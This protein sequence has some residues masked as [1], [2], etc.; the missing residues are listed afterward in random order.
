MN[1]IYNTAKRD[2]LNG[3]HDWDSG[4]QV[5]KVMLL[6]PGYTPDPD[7]EFVSSLAAYEIAGT[8][9]TGGFGGSG[10]KALVNRQVVADQANNRAEADADDVSWANATLVSV[11]AA[12]VYREGTSDAD[13]KLIA[14]F[15]SGFPVSPTAVDLILQWNAEGILQV[16]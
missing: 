14:Y 8:G 5:F 2:L 6:G 12:V 3:V 4:G 13:S 16:A 15:D 10:R 9:Y 11:T 1:L 7:H